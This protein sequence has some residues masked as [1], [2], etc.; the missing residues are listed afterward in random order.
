MNAEEALRFRG[1][2]LLKPFKWLKSRRRGVRG[3]RT[4]DF[5]SGPTPPFM[6]HP[7]RR[8]QKGLTAAPRKSGAPG[9]P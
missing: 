8:L 3:V 9:P 6:S 7:Q 1:V 2:L 4:S 5:R